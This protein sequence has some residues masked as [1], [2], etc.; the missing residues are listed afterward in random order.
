MLKQIVLHHPS[1]PSHESCYEPFQMEIV[2]KSQW[3]VS[4][5]R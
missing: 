2:L 4:N 1:P 5:D 3:N